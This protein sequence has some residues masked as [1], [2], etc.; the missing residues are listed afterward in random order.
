VFIFI[1]S[2]NHGNY[3]VCRG[4]RKDAEIALE[5]EREM[6]AKKFNFMKNSSICIIK[7]ATFFTR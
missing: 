5:R 3:F 2:Y 6:K 4:A 7:I 1:I